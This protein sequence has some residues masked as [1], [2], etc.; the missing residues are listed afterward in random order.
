M[1]A[2]PKRTPPTGTRGKPPAGRTPAVSSAAASAPAA[3]DAVDLKNYVSDELRKVLEEEE[4][5]MDG[6]MGSNCAF[7]RRMEHDVRATECGG[8]LKVGV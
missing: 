1:E 3:G 4:V 8:S 7:Q 5:G 2:R 6:S